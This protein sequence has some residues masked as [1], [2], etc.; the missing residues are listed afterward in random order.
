MLS[1]ASGS[2]KHSRVLVCTV[3]V[4]RIVSRP[5][6]L[7]TESYPWRQKASSSAKHESN[8]TLAR[9][10]G[11]LAEARQ[12]L[13]QQPSAGAVGSS[14]DSGEN[15]NGVKEA[16]SPPINSKSWALVLDA[17]S[18]ASSRALRQHAFYSPNR[19]VVPNDS[20]AA[21]DS[22]ASLA[23]HAQVLRG[24]SLHSYL[25]AQRW[26]S[27][28]PFACVFCD[29]TS[30]LDGSWRPSQELDIAGSAVNGTSV[31][32]QKITSPRDD[33]VTLFRGRGKRFRIDRSG[34]VL[35]V[36][37][38]HVRDTGRRARHRGHIVDQWEQLRLLV[39]TLAARKGLC[40]VPVPRRVEQT[41]VATEFWLLGEPGDPILTE[42]LVDECA[43]W[44]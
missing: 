29:F 28:G 39:G 26:A 5:R 27:Q 22:P 9:L 15:G 32:G 21:F 2:G 42:V 20:D 31:D 23:A 37:L 34:T 11:R 17:P 4:T 30:C 7:R 38:A 44:A 25:V 33:L 35:G 19:I 8:T 41:A 16:D 18:L 40:A 14:C 1:F 6:W 24:V 13:Q 36:T 10:A 12:R 43:Q 3:G